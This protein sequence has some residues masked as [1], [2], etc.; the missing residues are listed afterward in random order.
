MMRM[1]G[2]LL[3]P[4]FVLAA[5]PPVPAQTC[6]RINQL[7]YTPRSLKC[8][9]LG[10]ETA[11]EAPRRFFVCDA[12]T[13]SIV[14]ESGE[15]RTC[16]SWGPFGETYRLDFTQ[17][18]REGGV[19]IRA[20]DVSSPLFRINSDVYEGASDFLLG[21]LRQQQ[22]GYNPFLHDSCHTH[23]G[24]LTGD[25]ER[26]GEFVDVVGG[27][28]RR[29]RLPSLCH[30]IRDR[31]IPDAFCVPAQPRG[32]QRFLQPVGRPGAQRS[33]GHSRRGTVG[34]RMAGLT[35]V[36]FTPGTSSNADYTIP[37]MGESYKGSDA[38][39]PRILDVEESSPHGLNGY[40]LLLHIG[41]DPARQD[42]FARKLDALV[43]EL[44]RRGYEFSTFGDANTHRKPGS[45]R[46]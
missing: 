31:D 36:D 25:P 12:L 15:I 19:Y 7:G 8:A 43:T 9:V 10:S 2:K 22:C 26:E 21:Y 37:A 5:P 23:D 35:L 28:A 1:W 17:F 32:L 44:Q 16:G 41:T 6:I 3:I 11:I 42:K 40:I 38:I 4:L 29:I 39:F 34:T 46:K 13:D 20:G 24:Y 33:P 14:W 27:V 45:P 30:N 18:E